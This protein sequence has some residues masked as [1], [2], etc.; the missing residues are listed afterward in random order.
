MKDCA[1]RKP[2]QNNL[3]TTAK[4]S[5]AQEYAWRYSQLGTF[6]LKLGMPGYEVAQSKYASILLIELERRHAIQLWGSYIQ[7]PGEESNPPKPLYYGLF[8]RNHLP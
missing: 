1:P 4:P 5:R 7:M 6:R 3:K 2:G 8:A